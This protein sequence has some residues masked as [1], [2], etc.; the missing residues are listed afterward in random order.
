MEHT[1]GRRLRRVRANGNDHLRDDPTKC[2]IERAHGWMEQ[3]CRV[4]AST[5]AR[6]SCARVAAE[7]SRHLSY[8]CATTSYR[9]RTC[10]AGKPG[11]RR[12]KVHA[13]KT[14]SGTRKS[15]VSPQAQT[16]V[17]F[18]L[19]P[20]TVCAVAGMISSAWSA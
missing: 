15:R 5:E 8:Y 10:Y 1:E 3:A 9:R 13:G 20:F 11:S 4:P 2:P 17:T 7:H 12:S 16:E 6:S 18:P 19:F 14:M